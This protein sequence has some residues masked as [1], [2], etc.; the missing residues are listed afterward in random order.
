VLGR[1]VWLLSGQKKVGGHYKRVGGHGRRHGAHIVSWGEMQR[2]LLER[3]KRKKR[4]QKD[5]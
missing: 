1:G 5:A 4:V 2:T 3:K